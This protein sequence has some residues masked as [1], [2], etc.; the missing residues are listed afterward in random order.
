[1]KIQVQDGLTFK[2]GADC[3]TKGD[4]VPVYDK[5]KGVDT[6][7]IINKYTREPIIKPPRLWDTFTDSNDAAYANFDA[8]TIALAGI[9]SKDQST[10]SLVTDKGTV[11][12]ATSIT[13]GVTLNSLNGKVTTV[14]STLAADASASFVVTNSKVL[15]TSL[16]VPSVFYA[17]STGVVNVNITAQA[18]GSFTVKITNVGTAVLNATVTIG[19][20]VA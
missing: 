9:L 2:V 15:A 14:A 17:G 6:A 11:T 7:T 1:M 10:N 5:E 16:I 3:Y 12:Q 4:Y 19:F 18:A 8:F 13:T 20:L